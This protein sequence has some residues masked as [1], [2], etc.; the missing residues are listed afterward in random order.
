MVGIFRFDI[1]I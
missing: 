1:D